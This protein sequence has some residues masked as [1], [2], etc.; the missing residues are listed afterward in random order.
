MRIGSPRDRK[1]VDGWINV[2]HAEDKLGVIDSLPSLKTGT[3]WVW[4]PV[5]GILEQIQVRRIQTFDSYATPKPGEK[6]IEPKKLATIDID[7][8]GEQIQATLDRKKAED[9][10]NL[11]KALRI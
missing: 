1:A 5:R 10:K 8:L 11:Q 3:A 9:P 4:S 2:K 6:R 7:E